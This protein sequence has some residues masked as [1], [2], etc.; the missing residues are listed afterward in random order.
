MLAPIKVTKPLFVDIDLT[1]GTNTVT[2]GLTIDKDAIPGYFFMEDENIFENHSDLNYLK[3]YTI[4]DDHYL[5]G[6][7]MTPDELKQ[8]IPVEFYAPDAASNYVFKMH[9]GSDI[10]NIESLYL[11]DTK[12]NVQVDLLQSDYEFTV[13]AAGFAENRFYINVTLKE[14]TNVQTD[15]NNADSEIAPPIKFLYQD[16]VYILYN[17]LIY[18]ATGKKALEINK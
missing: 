7:T 9:D 2:A 13:P 17:G 15:I 16:K 11:F 12:E 18:D 14:E 5:V 10:D 1:H 3:L 8:L 6:N 4:A